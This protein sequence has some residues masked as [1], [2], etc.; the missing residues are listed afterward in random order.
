M[1]DFKEALKSSN[2]SEIPN[3]NEWLQL[4]KL[5]KDI[6]SYNEDK[7]AWTEFLSKKAKEAGFKDAGDLFSTIN[8]KDESGAKA[9][10]VLKSASQEYKER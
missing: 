4:R 9:K 3:F 8:K 5:E 7:T 10:K 6:E 2:V 1:F